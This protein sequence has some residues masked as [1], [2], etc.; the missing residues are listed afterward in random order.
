MSR[1]DGAVAVVTGAGNGI[2]AETA[3]TLARQGARVAMFDI[4]DEAVSTV[5]KE[6]AD[7][8]GTAYA[9]HLDVAS[10]DD[11]AAGVR[12][13]E[14]ELGAPI[15][16]LHSNAAI[17]N[18]ETLGRGI[19][20]PDLPFDVWQRV[21]T[22]NAGG[23]GLLACKHVLPSMLAAG[24]GSIVFTSSVTALV[25]KP[26]ILSYAAAKG[27]ILS[28][29]RGLAATYGDRGIRCNAVA[30]GPVETA[31]TATIDPALKLSLVRNS[32]I[33]RFAEPSDIANAVAFLLSDEASFITGQV[34]TVD[35]GLTARYPTAD[36][37]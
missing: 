24:R 22:V 37:G 10:E 3:R 11:W 1:F 13:A 34:L 16:L 19:D 8:G 15:T 30:P 31:A 35:G 17:T 36:Q 4:D 2:G 33:P 5:A 14:S 21:L 28:F 29:S 7:A 9:R 12:A 20:V 18:P 26:D 27:A 25:G 32:M 6:I 23:S